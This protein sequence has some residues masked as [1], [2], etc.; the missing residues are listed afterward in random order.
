MFVAIFIGIIGYSMSKAGV[1]SVL[2]GSSE[3]ETLIIKAALLL[4]NHGVLAVV[5][6][7]LILSGILACTMS[8]ADSQLLAAAS[9]VSHNLIGDCFG[10][11]LSQKASMLLA[12]LT[13]IG[14]AV[15]GVF[16]ARDPD[17]SVFKIVSFAW[18]G[19]GASFGPIVLFSLFWKRTNRAGA[20]AGM[21]TG[22]VMV[23][24]W[25]YLIAPMGES[26]RFTNCFRHFCAP[27]LRSSYSAC[28]HRLHP[29]KSSKNLR[30]SDR[31]LVAKSSYTEY[32][33]ILE[34]S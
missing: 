13:V 10:V 28:S 24:V 29:A 4:S 1:I 31:L 19:F 18:A 16:L 6:A 22:G 9:S 8:T 25:K 33:E 11:K 21:L 15:V 23:F 12:R 17:S 27:A 7:G 32:N 26:S 2:N 30:A 3:S 5:M 14:I 34:K 20:L